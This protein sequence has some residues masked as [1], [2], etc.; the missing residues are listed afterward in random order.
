M[1]LNGNVGGRYVFGLSLFF[2]CE[3]PSSSQESSALMIFL[4]HV[5]ISKSSRR[6]AWHG[7][8]KANLVKR[9]NFRRNSRPAYSDAYADERRLFLSFFFAR[10]VACIKRKTTLSTN[11]GAKA[12]L[13]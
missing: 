11:Y 6:H 9:H 1:K 2:V 5:E 8:S 3:A 13:I 7:L 12:F 4:W 10:P